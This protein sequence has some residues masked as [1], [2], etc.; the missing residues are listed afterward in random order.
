[1][2]ELSAAVISQIE[3]HPRFQSAHTVLLFHSLPD[4]V[5][6]RPLLRKYLEHKTL[7]LPTVV[8]DD[9]ELHI[10]TPQSP[11]H[12]GAFHI[13]ESAGPLLPPSA[14]HTIDLAII[15][16]VA[17]D[18]EGNR[19]GRGR[20]YYDRLLPRLRCHTIGICFPF[21][22][23]PHVPHEPHDMRVDE[24]LCG[25]DTARISSSPREDIVAG[26]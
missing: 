6:T 14:Y 12:E 25:V 19:L 16:A 18:P 8:G 21:Q 10:L 5:N 7:L 22:L 11:L 13:I 15:P 24:V 4:E 17:F 2:P 23:I 26:L 20:G 1:M 3:Q 9:L